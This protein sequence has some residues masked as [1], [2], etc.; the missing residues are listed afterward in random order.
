MNPNLIEIWKKSRESIE[1]FDKL[2]AE[3]RRMVFTIDGIALTVA[4]TLL[5]SSNEKRTTYVGY[6][7][8]GIS[9]I[10]VI[11]WAVEKHYHLYLVVSAKVAERI[12][13][14][15]GVDENVKLTAQL[16]MTSES[17]QPAFCC[18]GIKLSLY[19]AIYLVPAMISL[20]VCY[21]EGL[22]LLA[23]TFFIT[24][25]IAVFCLMGR[26]KI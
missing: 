5:L 21:L 7:G 25:A 9:I 23:V 26:R 6:L 24:E 17:E 11:V 1:H 20:I 3:F 8:L 18:R 22:H 4:V 15:L 19:D 2:L 12:E 10:N 16:R 14:V 13:D